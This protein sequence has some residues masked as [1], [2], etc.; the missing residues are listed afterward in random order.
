MVVVVNR[1]RRIG[2]LCLV[3]MIGVYAL[4]REAKAQW[5]TDGIVVGTVY[6]IFHSEYETD[7]A[8]FAQVD[9]DLPDIKAANIR[10]IMV[11]P[12]SQWNPETGEL[13][14]KRTDYLIRRIEELD[15]KFVPVMLKEEQCSHYFPIWKHRELDEIWAA[16]HSTSGNRNTR[17]NVDF[18]HPEVF[19]L[20]EQ[21]FKAVVER[22]RT[23][24]ALS[25][26]NIWNEPHYNH[27]GEHVVERFKIW[28]KEKYGDLVTL[29]RIWGE[30][31][32][33]WDEVTPFL[34][35]DWDSSMP[36]MDWVEFRNELN[37]QLLGELA[38]MLRKYDD[39]K[40]INANPVGSIWSGFGAYGSYNTD[41]WQF[42][43]YQ[44][45]NGIS[46][47]PDGWD[48]ANPL[49]PHPI[50]LHNLT[51]NSVR[52]ASGVKPYILTEV[53]T[54]AKNGLTLG[55]WL[56]PAKLRQ[57][58]WIALAN[59]CKGLIYW[60][61]EPFFRG[62]Q[63]LGRGLVRTDGSLAARGHAVRELG[64]Y[65]TRHGKV[66]YEARM[67]KPEVGI[68]LDGVG[69][70][71]VLEQPVDP[72]TRNYMFES[73]AGVFRALDEA[74]ISCDFV[75]TDFPCSLDVLQRYRVL[76]MPFQIV[77]RP[78]LADLLAAY[79]RAGGWLIADARTATVDERDFAYRLNPGAGLDLV[80]GVKRL[81]WVA[82]DCYY[83]VDWIANDL[84]SPERLKARWFREELE[85][86]PGTQVVARFSDDGSPAMTLLK[87]GRGA[88]LL[89]GFSI[90]ASIHKKEDGIMA[91]WLVELIASAG[92][93]PVASW[94]G[95]GFVMLR[96]HD[97]HEGNLIY[98]V[99][100]R[101][102]IAE[103][104]IVWRNAADKSIEDIDDK[105]VFDFDSTGSMKESL[106]LGPLEARVFRLRESE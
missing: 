5:D 70:L 51:F 36:G 62:R 44:D 73:N 68:L 78:E 46:Y 11:F 66:L 22:Y 14:F 101:E 59:G 92:V 2:S 96:V 7:D 8:F 16:H 37:G 75:R 23:S 25:F 38:E 88:A 79:V 49:Q 95:K 91:D 71:K 58:A 32:S 94:E 89:S 33:C 61:W 81:D 56:A 99:N 50:W 69:L 4:C 72:R 28:L 31:Y 10:Q 103:G 30:D 43:D 102:E 47:Y 21:Y 100:N 82:Y 1:I 57:L 39:I 15:L 77:I 67:S 63:S 27:H 48:R 76:I 97:Y 60:K 104:K 29:G 45:I 54:N 65:M 53:Y 34:N 35:D 40:P 83:D 13:D 55:G 52:S 19:P 18:A 74:N 26:Y 9:R 98:V 42:T 85:V 17:E 41:L 93:F 24:P 90:G 64:A 80:F 105:E 12:M 84:C 20:L 3:V 86:Y 6:N 106:S 87:H